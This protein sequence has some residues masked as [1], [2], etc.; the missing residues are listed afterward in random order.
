MD[1]DE[2]QD[3]EAGSEFYG[4]IGILLLYALLMPV[5]AIYFLFKVAW[6]LGRYLYRCLAN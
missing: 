5:F 6:A 2:R 4:G 1:W 3:Y